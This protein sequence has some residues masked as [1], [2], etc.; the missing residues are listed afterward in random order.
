VKCSQYLFSPYKD[1]TIEEIHQRAGHHNCLLKERHAMFVVAV[2]A[3]Q[4]HVTAI[5]HAHINKLHELM[6]QFTQNWVDGAIKSR[7]NVCRNKAQLIISKERCF[8]VLN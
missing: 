7:S 5:N 8:V 2:A 4:V 6:K 3:A 1:K